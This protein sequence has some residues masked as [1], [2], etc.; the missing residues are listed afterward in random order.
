MVNEPCKTSE[1]P[2]T[3]ILSHVVLSLVNRWRRHY[4]DNWEK[5]RVL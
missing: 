3:V 5:F 2:S 1:K 4:S